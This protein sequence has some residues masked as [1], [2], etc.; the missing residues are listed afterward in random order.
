MKLL[1]MFVINWVILEF[2][3]FVLQKYVRKTRKVHIC[4]EVLPE[5][6]EPE[7]E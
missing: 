6:E 3:K 2:P 4:R 1:P 7:N 5:M